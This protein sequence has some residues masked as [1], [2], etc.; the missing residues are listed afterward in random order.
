MSNNVPDWIGSRRIVDQY[1][2]FTK[3]IDIAL[4]EYRG[5]GMYN[6]NGQRVCSFHPESMME[7]LSVLGFNVV[8]DEE[9][10]DEI[11]K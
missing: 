4:R 2:K 9:D 6:N 10:F 1:P 8:E 11:H 5:A 7:Y 3:Q